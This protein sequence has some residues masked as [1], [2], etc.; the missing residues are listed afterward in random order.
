ME[1]ENDF[2]IGEESENI[3]QTRPAQRSARQS[4][5]KRPRKGQ[6][7]AMLKASQSN[8]D[9]KDS[10]DFEPEI[11]TKYRLKEVRIELKRV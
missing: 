10:S 2:Y 1:T 8:E 4:R 6:T 7:K 11:A 9:K 5:L 3:P